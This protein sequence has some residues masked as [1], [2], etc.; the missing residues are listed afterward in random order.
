MLDSEVRRWSAMPFEQ[1]VADVG[2]LLAYEI[3][4]DS[5]KYQVEVQLLKNAERS[6]QVIV[7]VDDVTLP[8]SF[9]PSTHIFICR[10]PSAAEES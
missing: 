7:A 6:V 10:K 9:V 8:R 2:D 1:L 4:V 5:K 3:E